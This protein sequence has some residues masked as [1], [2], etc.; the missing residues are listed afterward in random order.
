M[1]LLIAMSIAALV[2]AVSVPSTMRLYQTIQYREAVRDVVGLLTSA[3]YIAVKTGRAQDVKINPET[4]ELRLNE[5][6]KQLPSELRLVV[7]SA[8][9]LNQPDIGVLRFYPEG[10]S[11]GGG[12]DI[13]RPGGAGVK[14]TVDWLV[15]RVAQERYAVN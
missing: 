15:G 7:H 10:G 1:E 8:R 4:N 14:I 13:E 3:R 12:V 2:L 6:R 9:E 5:T 11:S